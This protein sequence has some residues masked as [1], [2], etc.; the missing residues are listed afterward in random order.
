VVKG[1]RHEFIE[2]DQRGPNLKQ[3][4]TW[5]DVW[6]KATGDP[7]V[8][9]YVEAEAASSIGELPDWPSYQSA[10]SG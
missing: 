10:G 8:G 4:P 2:V 1:R 7:N 5:W 6:V 9:P 3:G